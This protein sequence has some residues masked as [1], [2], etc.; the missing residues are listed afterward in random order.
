[1]I[2]HIIDESLRH[3]L[4]DLDGCRLRYP[5]LSNSAPA[6]GFQGA[7]GEAGATVRQMADRHHLSQAGGLYF[8]PLR[9][10]S[11]RKVAASHIQTLPL[12]PR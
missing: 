4:G 1:M 7:K 9:F 12:P 8:S 6:G 5:S 10:P 11:I 2:W 3:N